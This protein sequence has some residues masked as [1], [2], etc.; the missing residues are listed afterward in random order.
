MS[1]SNVANSWV[2]LP[3]L[4]GSVQQ[5]KLR[6]F[7]FPQAGSGAWVYQEWQSVA[8]DGVQVSYL[9]IFHLKIGLAFLPIT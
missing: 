9:D 2:L 3:K 8:P 5:P 7:C 1:A 6:L 4:D